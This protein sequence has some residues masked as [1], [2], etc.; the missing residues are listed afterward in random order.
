MDERLFDLLLGEPYSVILIPLEE[1]LFLLLQTFMI[2]IIIRPL[3]LN[4]RP[5]LVAIL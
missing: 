2:E 1:P 5:S 4:Q 3:L